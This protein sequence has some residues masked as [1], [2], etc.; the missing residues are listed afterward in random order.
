[1][2]GF[3]LIDKPIGITSFGV[4]REL[5]KITGIKKIGHCGTLDPMASGLLI[6]A[7][8]R[9]ATKKIYG[10]I[11]K[12]KTYLAE[13]ELGKISDT[14]DSEGIKK[15]KKIKTIPDLKKIDNVLESFIGE[16]E[17]I[18]PIFSAKK[19]GGKKA[20][21]IARSGK[22]PEIKPVR[23][24]IN[25]IKLINYSYPIIKIEVDCGSGTYIRSLANDI[26][27]KLK[28]GAYLKNLRRI[29][30]GDYNIKKSNL[31]NKLNENNWKNKI[32]LSEKHF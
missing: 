7:V 32:L 24:K 28:T 17:Q 20:Y 9:S 13:I 12:D 10:F 21:E 8:G 18:P 3:L 14:Y 25:N 16:Q 26:G 30:I 31:L 2:E 19:I 1:M 22:K 23:I 6:C 27:G 29:K 5:R 4:I 11:K 15:E